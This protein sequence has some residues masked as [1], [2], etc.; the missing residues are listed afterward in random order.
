MVP[1]HAAL[2]IGHKIPGLQEFLRIAGF[3][4]AAGGVAD[5]FGARPAS[6]VPRRDVDG[7]ALQVPAVSDLSYAQQALVSAL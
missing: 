1:A 2:S 7:L 3:A 5:D 4:I 6:L